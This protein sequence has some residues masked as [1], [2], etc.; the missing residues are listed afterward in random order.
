M[1]ASWRSASIRCWARS[2]P[3]LAAPCRQSRRGRSSR[4]STSSAT[5]SPRQAA[6][7]GP[8]SR[9]V[10]IDALQRLAAEVGRG[11]IPITVYGVPPDRS[12][13]ERLQEAGEV[14]SKVVE[15][16]VRRGGYETASALVKVESGRSSSMGG[17][18][19]AQMLTE[20]SQIERQ[21]L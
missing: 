2:L 19:T 13:I 6:D 16:A 12:A 18:R 1:S 9:A 17:G 10:R 11:P 7:T 15:T 4:S 21:P 3:R 14:V 20:C 8:A 5:A